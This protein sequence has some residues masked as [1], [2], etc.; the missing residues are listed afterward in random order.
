M[1]T[2]VAG[3]ALASILAVWPA[4]AQAQTSP[5]LTIEQRKA[6]YAPWSPEQMV[7][8]RKEQELKGPGPQRPVPPPAFPSY[9]KAP[10]SVE[11]LMPQARAA[12][13]YQQQATLQSVQES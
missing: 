6:I 4:L 1:K 8:R 13:P 5:D 9:L 11:E 2:A 7:Q 12:A 10:G 3:A